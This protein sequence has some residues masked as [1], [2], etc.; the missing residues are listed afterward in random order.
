MGGT[1]E[2][3]ITDDGARIQPFL[4]FQ[5]QGE[6]SGLDFDA[7]SQ[8]GHVE[9]IEMGVL[10]DEDTSSTTAFNPAAYATHDS[11]G[12][13]ANSDA[14]VAAWDPNTG[15]WTA[16]TDGET[17]YASLQIDPPSGGLYGLSNVLDS[18]GA[19][20]YGIEPSAI[21][22]FWPA[23]E[24]GHTNPGT[25]APS[26]GS[27]DTSS[28]ITVNAEAVTLT[29]GK[30]WDAVSSL[31]MSNTIS[32]DVMMN[33][34]VNGM[35][36][37]IVTFP[38]KREYVNTT[39]A[40]NP[41]GD[42][43]ARGT[44]TKPLTYEADNL[45]C[46][47]IGVKQWN[48]EESTPALTGKPIFSPAPPG[49]EYVPFQLCLETNTI[50]MGAAGT[51]SVTNTVLATE[52]AEYLP[53]SNLSF[54]AGEDEGWMQMTFKATVSGSEIA[55]HQFIE[56]ATTSKSQAT[57]KYLDGLPVMGFAAYKYGNGDREYGFVSDHKTSK[58]GSAITSAG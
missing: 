2:G 47:A 46:E 34:V 51:A 33:P 57:G 55:P 4:P 3:F 9:V 11:A 43:Y 48:R 24:S 12:I 7:R 8:V 53:A 38:T 16:A 28:I 5:Y 31:F 36:D 39:T 52:G 37:W 14:L 41:F 56:V 29:F 58:A 27:G 15:K 20:A 40:T 10:T 6:Y 25:T 35:T 21:D 42:A 18:N 50:A 13:P 54:I 32:N 22:D 49:A 44:K 30:G 1:L 17:G 45:A 26:L 23:G 19:S